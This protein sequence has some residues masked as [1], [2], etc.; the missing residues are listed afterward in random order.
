MSAIL[1]PASEKW[2]V[3]W[4]GFASG[5]WQSRGNVREILQRNYP[6]YEGDDACLQGATAR[7][8]GMWETPQPLL[9]KEHEKGILDVIATGEITMVRNILVVSLLAMLLAAPGLH[10]QTAPARTAQPAANAVDTASIQALKDMGAHLQTLKRF[11]VSTELTGERVL[12]DGE[13]LQHSARADMDVARP[14]KLRARS[15]SRATSGD[16]AWCNSTAFSTRATRC[17]TRAAQSASA[18]TIRAVHVSDTRHLS[19]SPC[20][21]GSASE[22]R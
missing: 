3:A 22:S 17:R 9:A 13:K 10:A 16:F 15:H 1:K 5:S 19:V 11:R 18:L 6:P 21:R 2:D 20:K 7:T 12:K 8:R 14:S 4:R